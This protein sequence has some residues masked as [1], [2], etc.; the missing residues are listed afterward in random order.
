MHFKILM[1]IWHTCIRIEFTF[2]NQVYFHVRV[3]ASVVKENPEEGGR[4]VYL[5][6][7][8]WCSELF[9]YAHVYWTPSSYVWIFLLG[10]QFRK[11]LYLMLLLQI[12]AR[13]EG[14]QHF[15]GPGPGLQIPETGLWDDPTQRVC[16]RSALLTKEVLRA[17]VSQ[18]CALSVTVYRPFPEAWEGYLRNPSSGRSRSQFCSERLN[19][20]TM[21]LLQL[22][23]V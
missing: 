18:D 16:L 7:F 8:R 2:V 11:H 1:I 5:I 3:F 20:I 13:V 6:C 22:T 9:T 19:Q 14:W 15:L 23:Q 4:Y 21:T 12:L 17:G 10:W